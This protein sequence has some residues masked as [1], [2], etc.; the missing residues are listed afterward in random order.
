VLAEILRQ[1]CFN[2]YINCTASTERCASCSIYATLHW[3]M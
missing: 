2:H 3:R 1:Y